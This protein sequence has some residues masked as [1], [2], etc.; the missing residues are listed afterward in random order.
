MK[1]SLATL[2]LSLIV[3]LPAYTQTAD[4]LDI[5]AQQLNDT[6]SIN[7]LIN[8]CFRFRD[9]QTA[10]CLRLSSL[11]LEASTKLGFREG[12]ARSLTNLGSMESVKGN[13][14]NALKN[15]F[16]ALEKWEELKVPRGIMLAKNNI[17]MVYGDMKKQDEQFR[18]LNEALVLA[19]QYKMDDGLALVKQNFSI[20][21]AAKGDFRSAFNTQMEAI[22]LFLL[23]EKKNEAAL[24]YGNAGAYQFYM[25]KID[26]ALV[27]YQQAKQI[28][29]ELGD[30]RVISMSLA[31]I[32][33]AYENQKN[34]PLAIENYDKCIAIATPLKLNMPLRFCYGQLAG[35]YQ[36]KGDLQQTIRYIK[37]E[38]AVADSMLNLAS[39]KQINEL[40]ISYE[41]AK[42]EQQI[43]QQQ[44]ALTKKNYWIAGISAVL[45]LGGLLAYS[46]YRSNRLKQSRKL[47]EAIMQQQELSA[48]AV[49]AAEENERQRIARDLHDGIG[50][51]MSAAKMNL[52][53][54][55]SRL[56][57]STDADKEAFDRIV[58][59]VDESCKE[60]RSVSHT[61]MPN[62][63]LKSGLGTAMKDFIEKID[64]HALKVNLY[65]EGL[66]ERLDA[67]IETV[68]YRVIQECV[69]NVIK[70]S[71]A[72]TL[73]ISLIRDKDGIAAT[74]ED[75]G[76]GFDSRQL[77][78]AAGIGLKNI[79]ARVQYLH[80]TVDF[81]SQPGKGTLVAIHVPL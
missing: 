36:Q 44:F 51:T 40:Q 5:Y 8:A 29:E 20:Y 53:G 37:L 52:S 58:G 81:D 79:A 75:N 32:G 46:F 18:Y 49:I 22:S 59:L 38:Q 21:Y 57:F 66:Q 48:K 19:K 10:K 71:G 23:Q 11:T 14:A 45:L 55:E 41:T 78:E 56:H 72:N 76:C 4:S 74:I 31:N 60:V 42:K 54:L 16:A 50:Q 39:A 43:Q 47:Q 13:F 6:T 33:E 63:L 24:G 69:N 65:T 67:N 73:D 64:S 70:H 77:S 35:I 28:G 1:R 34:I 61:M 68:L 30:P 26:S 9:E 7:R 2:F 27:F 62:V 12:E 3:F 15:Y 17:G 80:G 25:G